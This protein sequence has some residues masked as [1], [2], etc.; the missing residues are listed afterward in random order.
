MAKSQRPAATSTG[1]MT[2]AEEVVLQGYLLPDESNE[3]YQQLV[4]QT[5]NEFAPRTPYQRRLVINLAQIEWELIRHRRLLAATVRTGF[6]E[7]AFATGK[8]KA[9]G[10]EPAFLETTYDASGLSQ[11]LLSDS[12]ED[13]HRGEERLA[14]LQ[15]TRSEITAAAY[16]FAS[17][18]VSWHENRISDLE[19]RRRTLLNDLKALLDSKEP[20]PPIID[21]EILK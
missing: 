16:R 20:P 10:H 13:R 2:A 7:Q 12:P 1:K 15:V 9:P 6:R 17:D 5:L 4:A 18:Q 21:A 14:K 3:D 8:H 11:D 19:R